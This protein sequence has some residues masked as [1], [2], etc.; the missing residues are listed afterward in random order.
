[1]LAMIFGAIPVLPTSCRVGSQCHADRILPET[2][3][4][5]SGLP[6]P[7]LGTVHGASHLPGAEPGGNPRR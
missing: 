2:S 1:M 7:K 5:S 4:G 6:W 3:L